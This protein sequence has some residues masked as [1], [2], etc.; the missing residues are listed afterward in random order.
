MYLGLP[1][2]SKNPRESSPFGDLLAWSPCELLASACCG[3]LVGS[4]AAAQAL[5]RARAMWADVAAPAAL[6]ASTLAEDDINATTTMAVAAFDFTALSAVPR[7]SR[8]ALHIL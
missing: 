3:L 2:L 5:S 1:S 4:A 6:K 8:R 7:L